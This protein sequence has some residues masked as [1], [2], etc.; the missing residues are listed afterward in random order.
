MFDATLRALAGQPDGYLEQLDWLSGLDITAA[1]A[2]QGAGV[3][4]GSTVSG[5]KHPHGVE[6]PT[7]Q[8]WRGPQP[9]RV[10][11]MGSLWPRY[12]SQHSQKDDYPRAPPMKVPAPV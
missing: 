5:V 9:C 2:K 6:H 3:W 12:L 1:G 8:A 10:L 7:P 4:T 11:R